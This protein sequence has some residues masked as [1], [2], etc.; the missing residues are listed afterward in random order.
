ML[1]A[2]VALYTQHHPWAGAHATYQVV[3]DDVGLND[4]IT[5]RSAPLV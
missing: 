2:L 5:V 4:L 1:G 3:N